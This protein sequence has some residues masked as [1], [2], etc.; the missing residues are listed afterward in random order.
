MTVDHISINTGAHYGFR[1]RT[2][3]DNCRNGFKELEFMVDLMSHM[4]DGSDYSYLETKFGLKAGEG[5]TVQ[6]EIT[7]ALA[8]L[9]TDDPV[10]GVYT[11]IKGLFARLG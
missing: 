11:A 3:L 7:S 4:N 9:R 1:L 6:S 8:L 10:S 5:Q 2:A